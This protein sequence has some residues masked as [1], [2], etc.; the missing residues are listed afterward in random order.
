MGGS[1]S[2]TD[3]RD[4]IINFQKNYLGQENATQ[5]QNFLQMSEDFY[6][7]FTSC[8]LDDYRKVKESKPDNI[9]YLMSYVSLP[10]TI[11]PSIH[12]FTHSYYDLPLT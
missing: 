1:F 2:A 6:N 7:V 12:S 4:Q 11:H 8:Y 5:L 10:S 9:I 3:Y